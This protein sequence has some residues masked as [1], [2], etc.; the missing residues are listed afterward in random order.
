MVRVNREDWE[1]MPGFG[2]EESRHVWLCGD[3]NRQ[4][5]VVS[6]EDR[7]HMST[8]AMES[9]Q[10]K[11]TRTGP[12]EDQLSAWGRHQHQAPAS[13]ERGSDL[14]QSPFPLVFSWDV[15][16]I[17]GCSVALTHPS[18]MT[19]SLLGYDAVC[20]LRDKWGR[21]KKAIKPKFKLWLRLNSAYILWA[22]LPA[23]P[24]LCCPWI[25][26]RVVEFDLSRGREW[27]AVEVGAV[28]KWLQKH[29]SLWVSCQTL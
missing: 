19:M 13:P 1:A 22:L 21:E 6:V 5:R 27:S 2:E 12:G 14:F 3:K 15:A 25:L 9:E 17:S 26:N 16:Y 11:L 4:A 8:A 18:V 10:Q 29:N 7:G 20:R 24:F 23:F 28:T